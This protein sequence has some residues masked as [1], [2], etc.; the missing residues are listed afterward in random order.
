MN[1]RA[2]LVGLGAV[3]AAPRAAQGQQAGKVWRIVYVIPGAP[4]CPPTMAKQLGLLMEAV[5]Q[6]SA[7]WRFFRIRP[8]KVTHPR[9]MRKS[10]TAADP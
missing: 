8:I 4:E 6:K 1:R 5:P 3:L 9:W 7:A 2:F 10:R